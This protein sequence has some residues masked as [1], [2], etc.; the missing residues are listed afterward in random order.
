MKYLWNKKPDKCEMRISK[1]RHT[2]KN[3][4]KKMKLPP[5]FLLYTGARMW[6]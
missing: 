2:I 1:P 6:L 4:G 5:Q 3:I